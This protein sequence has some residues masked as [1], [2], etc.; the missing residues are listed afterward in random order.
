MRIGLFYFWII[1]LF[2][3]FSCKKPSQNSRVM[4]IENQKWVLKT[5][6]GKAFEN[7]KDATKRVFLT[8][9]SQNKKITGSG[10][11]NSFSGDYELKLDGS[12]K[13]SDMIS[14]EMFCED[15]METERTF[16]R[17]IAETQKM[18]VSKDK[19][20]LHLLSATNTSLAILELEKE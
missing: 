10:G 14:T 8:L 4:A 18:S 6:Q 17:A 11:C 15:R 2:A 20:S 5:L 12:F 7:P 16:F 1:V 13:I 19:K 9:N 3:G